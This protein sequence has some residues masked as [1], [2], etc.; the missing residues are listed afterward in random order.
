LSAGAGV[1]ANTGVAG[2]GVGAGLGL[3]LGIG[4]GVTPGGPGGPSGP[5][6]GGTGVN[7]GAVS[8]AMFELSP[9]ERIQLRRRC[10]DVL[11]NPRI[12]KRETLAICKLVGSR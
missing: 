8:F 10:A 4:L 5:G 12:A 9:V 2:T 7:P 11:A 1:G 3:G 6:T